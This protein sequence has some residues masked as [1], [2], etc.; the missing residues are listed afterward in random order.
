VFV[1]A[2][3]ATRAEAAAKASADV[4]VRR[5]VRVK[6]FLLSSMV[7]LLGDPGIRRGAGSDVG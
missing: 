6:A 4:A 2:Q 5:R 7:A 3:P 1:V